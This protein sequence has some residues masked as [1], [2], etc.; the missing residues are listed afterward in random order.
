MMNV[1]D[2][3][4]DA[5]SS[6]AG[7]PHGLSDNVAALVRNVGEWTAGMIRIAKHEDRDYIEQSLGGFVRDDDPEVTKV[8]LGLVAQEIQMRQDLLA[9]ADVLEEA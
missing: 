6:R 9:V 4:A 2:L 5:W 1:I 7:H 3:L 8:V